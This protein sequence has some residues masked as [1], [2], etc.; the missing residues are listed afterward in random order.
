MARAFVL[1]AGFGGVAA[2]TRLRSLLDPRHE[3]VLVD[4]RT[5]FVMGLR[6]TWAVV[7]AS[8]LEEGRREL[9]ILREQGIDVRQATAEAIDPAARRVQ[10]DGEWLEAD[11]VV[12]ALGAELV[13]GAVQGIAEHGIN[14]WD[15]ANTQTAHD[16]LVAIDHGRLLVS[17][18]GTPYACPPGPFEL[19]MLAHEALR[20]RGVEVSVEVLIRDRRE[21]PEGQHLPGRIRDL[22][23]HALRSGFRVLV[24]WGQ[25]ALPH[26]E[27]HDGHSEL[28]R[29]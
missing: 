3:V 19:A 29:W 4:R 24:E 10:L 27:Q 2:A 26:D 15:R 7:G 5:D 14:V 9:A 16:A 6:K 23:L 17:V 13:P 25:Q 21:W 20:A 18:F 8:P 11:A 12:V 1:G 22:F 28:G